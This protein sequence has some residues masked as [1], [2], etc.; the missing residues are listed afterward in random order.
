MR[1]SSVQVC[2]NHVS[3][4][5]IVHDYWTRA[6]AAHSNGARWH[7]EHTTPLYSS[8]TSYHVLSRSSAEAHTFW[9]RSVWT[10]QIMHSAGQRNGARND[11][12]TVYCCSVECATCMAYM[13]AIVKNLDRQW[14]NRCCLTRWYGIAVASHMPIFFQFEHLILI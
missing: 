14:R 5:A 11:G 7:A 12:T 8:C 13:W 3:V 9:Q 1:Y 10:M 2:L 6:D 4:H